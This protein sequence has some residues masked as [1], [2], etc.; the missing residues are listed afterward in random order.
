MEKFK[1]LAKGTTHEVEMDIL[2]TWDEMDIL[3]Q[4][5]NQ[6]SKENNFVFYDGP[7]TANGMPGLHHMMAKF[8]KDTICKYKTMKGFRVVRKVGWDTHGL[9]VELQVE[10]ELGF[11]SKTDIEKYGIKE[12]IRNVEKASGKM[13][14]RFLI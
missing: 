10:K 6:R 12:L 7:A 14:K 4:S 8:L 2:K 11:T 9:P 3:N 1:E 13:K 5:I